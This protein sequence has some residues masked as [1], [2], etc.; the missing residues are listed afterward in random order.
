MNLESSLQKF[1]FTLCVTSFSE[2]WTTIGTVWM[3]LIWR[4]DSF[5]PLQRP[6]KKMMER[7]SLSV[8]TSKK[9]PFLLLNLLWG[10]TQG[11]ECQ[12]ILL[13]LEIAFLLDLLLQQQVFS[14]MSVSTPVDLIHSEHEK[15]LSH[16]WPVDL[17]TW[18]N[19]HSLYSLVFQGFFLYIL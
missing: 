7:V 19:A 12:A 1:R 3:I 18:D 13:M 15:M 2:V 14:G 9:C 6:S 16:V 17:C 5:L 4:V 11:S 8:I 10:T